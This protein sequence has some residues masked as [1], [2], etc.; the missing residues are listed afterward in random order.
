MLGKEPKGKP[1]RWHSRGQRWKLK[2]REEQLDW[3]S[4]TRS[5]AVVP[6]V[7]TH[8]L[9]NWMP[10]SVVEPSRLTKRRRLLS[11]GTMASDS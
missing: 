2:C 5:V 6:E 1:D 3:T 8:L 11:V 10:L 7:P 9:A 4:E